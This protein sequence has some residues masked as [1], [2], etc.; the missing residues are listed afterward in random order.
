MEQTGENEMKSE[1]QLLYE[2]KFQALLENME[3]DRELKNE[4]FDSISKIEEL[5]SIID[6]FTGKFAQ[7]Q[8]DL[9]N[10]PGITKIDNS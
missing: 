2:K 4:V 7:S 5:T 9:L 8:I 1:V 10:S 6:L 3:T